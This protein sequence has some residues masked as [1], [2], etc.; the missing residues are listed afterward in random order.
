MFVGVFHPYIQEKGDK[1][2][3]FIT[4]HLLFIIIITQ[5]SGK[6]FRVFAMMCQWRESAVNSS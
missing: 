1:R 4:L 6:T 5:L 3:V 2:A